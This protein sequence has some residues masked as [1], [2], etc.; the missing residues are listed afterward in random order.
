LGLIGEGEMPKYNCS[1]GD[2]LDML[3]EEC[4]E[5]IKELM[6]RKR[7]GDDGIA[8]YKGT[9]PKEN[10]IQEMGDVLAVIDILISRGY[11]TEIQLA[12]AKERKIN[13]LIQLFGLV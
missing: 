6:K 13:R 2:P 8:E 7:F 1:M 11:I 5:L 3:A 9:K 12:N 10:I 4:A